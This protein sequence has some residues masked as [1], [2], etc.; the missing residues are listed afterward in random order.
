MRLQRETPCAQTKIK[1]RVK[2]HLCEE[3]HSLLDVIAVGEFLKNIFIRI[4]VLFFVFTTC[5]NASAYPCEKWLTRKNAARIGKL[6]AFTVLTSIPFIAADIWAE[7]K[8]LQGFHELLDQHIWGSDAISDWMSMGALESNDARDLFEKQI[9][10]FQSNLQPLRQRREDLLRIGWWSPKA[11]ELTEK[12]MNRIGADAPKLIVSE[13]L[14]KRVTEDPDYPELLEDIGEKNNFTLVL[15]LVPRVDYLGKSDIEWLSYLVQTKHDKELSSQQKFGLESLRLMFQTDKN[16]ISL[17]TF[18]DVTARTMKNPK[19]IKEKMAKAKSF[20]LPYTED[21]FYRAD[22]PLE[23]LKVKDG[24]RELKF[25]DEVDRWKMI[26]TDARFKKLADAWRRH[27]V[28][29]YDILALFEAY[30]S[31]QSPSRP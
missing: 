31:R 12:I 24:D 21:T 11:G 17:P 23:I 9:Q 10:L 19:E 14:V 26:L 18:A 4:V 25:E 28:A 3:R 22:L 5:V 2:F 8:D 30:W 1:K 29:D 7:R 27:D 20:G 16:K 15:W 13:D 6:V